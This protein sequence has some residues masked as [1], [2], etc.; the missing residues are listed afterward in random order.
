MLVS[1]SIKSMIYRPRS[2]H[3]FIKLGKNEYYR[4]KM[5]RTRS[6]SGANPRA[7]VVDKIEEKVGKDLVALNHG[8]YIC[9]NVYS[10]AAYVLDHVYNTH[11]IDLP[12][13]RPN[14]R[15]PQ[16]RQY[17]YVMGKD[18][19]EYDE[20]H[21][22]CPSCWFHCPMDELEVFHAHTVEEHDPVRIRP[23]FEE[24]NGSGRRRSSRPSSRQSN[25]P[26]SRQSIRRPSS[27]L[28]DRSSSRPNS[29]Q[30]HTSGEKE[31]PV[32]RPRSRQGHVSGEREGEDD[33]E[34]VSTARD[35]G[36]K[37]ISQKM[38]ELKDL[39]LTLFNK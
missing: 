7:Y 37:E 3:N 18:A 26:S 31:D 17:D 33:R 27:R 21:Y 8:C 35:N 32:S 23:E 30:G 4:R 29:R 9:G 2:H 14:I 34:H 15:R 28:S 19:V 10:S 22:A 24:E 36:K 20:E 38:D 39:F 1:L 11:G 6:R 5:Y 12:A 13:R 25:R 16:D